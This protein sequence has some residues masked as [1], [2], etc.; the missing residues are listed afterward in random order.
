[1]ARF[2]ELVVST[3]H[4]V[5]G[6]LGDAGVVLQCGGHLH[7]I[8]LE[9][10]Q[11]HRSAAGVLERFFRLCQADLQISHVFDLPLERFIFREVDRFQPIDPF[12]ECGIF[13]RESVALFC[14]RFEIFFQGIDQL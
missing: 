7:Q 5:P 12:F 8:V 14:D 9:T 6:F 13:A 2:H 10:F 1:M 11:T 3:L 4:D